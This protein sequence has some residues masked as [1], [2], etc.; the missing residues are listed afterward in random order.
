MASDR[1]ISLK[2]EGIEE[3]RH[4][5]TEL[6]QEIGKSVLVDSLWA[7]GQ[8]VRRE[9]AHMAPRGRTG[10][11]KNSV[12]VRY[13]GG[14]RPSWFAT[15]KGAGIQLDVGPDYRKKGNAAHLVERGTKPHK[16]TAGQRVSGKKI[17]TFR[18][19]KAMILAS[20]FKDQGVPGQ[21]GFF[22]KQVTVSA[23]P[24]PFLL[25]AFQSSYRSAIDK[26]KSML[27]YNIERAWDKVKK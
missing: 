9:I 8:I 2:V 19:T 6:P 4:A 21:R 17:R 24:H 15:A 27:N 13:H 16:I 12:T 20:K 5:L 11:L 18:Q 14:K 22:G 1:G 25:P 26:I 10:N 23:K 3:L 7:G